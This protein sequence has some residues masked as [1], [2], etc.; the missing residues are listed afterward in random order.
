M[1]RLETNFCYL[2]LAYRIAIERLDSSGERGAM[3]IPE[4]IQ[5]C[6]A[7]AVT[8]GLPLDEEHEMYRRSAVRIARKRLYIE[9]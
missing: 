3:A 7:Y 6:D 9:D 5:W 4:L 1:E 2:P 8:Y